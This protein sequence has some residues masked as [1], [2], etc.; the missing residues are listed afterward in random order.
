[1]KL[2]KKLLISIL[3]L[4]VN[5]AFAQFMP[6][7]YYQLQGTPFKLECQEGDGLMA[8]Y[9]SDFRLQ[10]SIMT[11]KEPTIDFYL[12]NE[13]P[14]RQVP[15]DKF[16]TRWQGGL[17]SPYSGY[18]KFTVRADDG[19]RVWI[20]GKI[21]LDE[22]HEQMVESYDFSVRMNEGEMHTI[23]VEY[24]QLQ[25]RH[26]VAQLYWEYDGRRKTIV[27]TKYLY[28]NPSIL[29]NEFDKIEE[30]VEEEISVKRIEKKKPSV[31][32]PYVVKD[33]IGEEEIIEKEIVEITE[34]EVVEESEIFKG[35]P[36]KKSINL[37]NIYFE[38]GKY[39]F[40][41]DGITQKTLQELVNALKK[42][43][44]LKVKIVGHTDNVGNYN[45]NLRLSRNRASKVVSHLVLS[46]IKPSRLSSEGFGSS[47]PIASNETESGRRK[48]R[49]VELVVMK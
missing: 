24:L 41:Q 32:D 9:F 36:D 19:I 48:N 11:V 8:E 42:Y 15:A 18:Y 22:W 37:E 4:S 34:E 38:Q 7:D 13:K 44:S 35:L 39:E 29:C 43:D 47:N 16:T 30:T 5:I 2:T 33:E 46:G 14:Y 40:K 31:G 23:K 26:A 45:A 6:S 49:R 10:R 12:L 1:M 3:L 27:P 20:D 21:M 17:Y 28:T 25:L